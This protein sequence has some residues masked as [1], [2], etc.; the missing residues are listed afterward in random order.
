MFQPLQ[1]RTSYAPKNK[2]GNKLSRLGYLDQIILCTYRVLVAFPF[3]RRHLWFVNALLTILLS[4]YIDRSY[5]RCRC[6]PSK[7]EFLLKPTPPD[8]NATSLGGSSA[9]IV[10][11]TFCSW[12]R[13]AAALIKCPL[14]AF[15]IGHSRSLLLIIRLQRCTAVVIRS[16][17]L[18]RPIRYT[19]QNRSPVF[20]KPFCAAHLSTS[21]SGFNVGTARD[22][23]SGASKN[24]G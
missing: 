14:T 20:P 6:C 15:D 2:G 24:T 7:Q 17:E 22:A 1:L 9:L 12:L 8:C 19:G 3:D 13:F 23:G 18:V 11:I 4:Y 16:V 10:S 5:P 21:F